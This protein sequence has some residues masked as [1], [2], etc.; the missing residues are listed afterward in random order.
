MKGMS[1]LDSVPKAAWMKAGEKAP[2]K[3]R[4]SKRNLLRTE[5]DEG[6]QTD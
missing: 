3:Q 4:S 5:V 2:R 6:N 1:G